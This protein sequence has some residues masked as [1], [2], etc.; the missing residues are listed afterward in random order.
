ME[1]TFIFFATHAIPNII[2]CIR[3]L[4]EG[5]RKAQEKMEVTFLAPPGV[6]YPGLQPF[7]V[8]AQAEP[9]KKQQAGGQASGSGALGSLCLGLRLHFLLCLRGPELPALGPQKGVPGGCSETHFRLRCVLAPGGRP[10]LSTGAHR[11]GPACTEGQTEL[12]ILPWWF[13]NRPPFGGDMVWGAG[14]TVH[15]LSLTST[16]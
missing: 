16:C 12:W 2:L 4:G 14:C 8:S 3:I 5:R 6:S 11:N 9:Q 7:R 13:R 1:P 10:F 15:T